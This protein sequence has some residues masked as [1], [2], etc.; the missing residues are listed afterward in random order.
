MSLHHEAD[1]QN[2]LRLWESSG[3]EKLRNPGDLQ[4]SW[5]HWCSERTDLSRRPGGKLEIPRWKLGSSCV[6]MI[7]A[8]HGPNELGP[9][10][11]KP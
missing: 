7:P 10:Y 1:L 4:L 11:G 8:V 3:D 9:S 6:A 2:H 5:V